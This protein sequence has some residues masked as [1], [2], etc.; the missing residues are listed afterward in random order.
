MDD[1]VGGI[2]SHF[3]GALWKVAS[4]AQTY[5]AQQEFKQYYHTLAYDT[6]D[7]PNPC[8]YQI[9][10]DIKRTFPEDVFF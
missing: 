9:E 1:V 2:P 6:E 10:I 7:Y 3:R 8:F 5:L 4:G